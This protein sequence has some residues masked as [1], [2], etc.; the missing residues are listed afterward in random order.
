MTV[1]GD[2]LLPGAD[3]AEEFDVSSAEEI[4]PGTVM[5]IDEEGALR[6]SSRAYDKT[7]AGVVS[8]G[9]DYRAGIVLELPSI[10]L[11]VVGMAV[12]PSGSAS[13]LL[14]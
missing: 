4:E 12:P 2:V 9:G 5:V 8:G 6:E 10:G 13:S 1:G 3:C 14:G 7:V 11:M